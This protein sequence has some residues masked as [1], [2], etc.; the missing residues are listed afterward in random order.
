MQR[1]G[2]L[3]QK[4][5]SRI[6]LNG[7]RGCH[8]QL[9]GHLPV[10]LSFLLCKFLNRQGCNLRFSPTGARM[11]EDGFVIPGTYTALSDSRGLL[12]TLKTEL[13]K[14]TLTLKH[15]KLETDNITTKWIISYH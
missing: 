11:L 13:D 9:V 15:M 2:G 5:R 8:E 1:G 4:S 10:E 7:D 6:Y 12:E 14:K 3:L